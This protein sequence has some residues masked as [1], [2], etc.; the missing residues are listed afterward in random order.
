MRKIVKTI[1]LT[2]DYEEAVRNLEGRFPAPSHVRKRLTVST[3]ARTGDGIVR[4]VLACNVIPT[5]FH[6]LAYELWNTVSQLPDNRPAAVG[7]PSLRRIKSDGL[8]S[9]RTGVSKQTLEALR[10][11]GT[12]YGMLG[13]LDETP[14]EACHR[15]PLTKAH[16]EMLEGNERLI[17]LVDELYRFYLPDVYERQRVEIAKVPLWRLWDTVFSTIYLARNF[18]TAYHFD[19]GNLKGVMTALMPMGNFTG[20]ELVLPRW[21][22]SIAFKPGDIL[23]FD[24][25]AILHGNLPIDGPTLSAAYY[26]ESD[27]AECGDL[28]R[29]N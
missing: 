14:S 12:A 5:A 27:I 26:C 28:V 11:R 21:C 17:K 1:L 19:S 29:A 9:G 7:S 2:P 18:R 4:V 20:G 22:L 25:P 23:F 6:K 13:Y 15:T 16:P 10:K 3:K 8:L 24:S